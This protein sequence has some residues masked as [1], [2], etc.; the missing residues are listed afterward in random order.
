MVNFWPIVFASFVST[1]QP[2]DKLPS[3]HLD[4]SCWMLTMPID[5]PYEG[6][7][8]EIEHPEFARFS[9]SRYFF[10][11]ESGDG[12]VFR[13]PCGGV[14]TKGSKFPRC[15]LREMT[16]A[17]TKRAAWSNDD[18][19]S[20][21]LNV[22]LAITKTPP[23]KNHLVCAQIHNADD[24][25]MMIRLEGTKL[26]IERNDVG[27]IMLDRKYVAGTRVELKIES[28]SG[29]VKVWYNGE[30]KM[31]WKTS[32]AG[33]YFKAGC[34]TQSNLSKGD[35]AESYGEVVIYELKVDHQPLP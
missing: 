18:K 32:E 17:G 27:D 29:H 10:V 30:Q 31:D 26:F 9:D 33:C 35:A 6:T 20:H 4:L 11:N 19:Q 24:D 3:E 28:A 22:K 5:T 2:Q 8:D 12:V 13:A 1:A 14:S 34:Y 16:K 7:P 25:V 23:V 21:T 15:E